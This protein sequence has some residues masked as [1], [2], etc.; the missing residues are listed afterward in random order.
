MEV[1][2]EDGAFRTCYFWGKLQTRP[3]HPPFDEVSPPE[4]VVDEVSPVAKG[5]MPS[6]HEALKGAP[7]LSTYQERTWLWG[8]IWNSLSWKNLAIA[9]VDEV[10]PVTSGEISVMPPAGRGSLGHCSLGTSR[11]AVEGASSCSAVFWR[12]CSP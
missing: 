6:V 8:R 12:H 11:K 7:G 4:G 1:H 2:A 9:V 5:V 10:S 3:S